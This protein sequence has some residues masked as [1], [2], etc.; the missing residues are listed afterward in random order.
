[1]HYWRSPTCFRIFYMPSV[2]SS[3]MFYASIC[4]CHVYPLGFCFYLSQWPSVCIFAL[5]CS[6]S[7]QLSFG[8]G[9]QRS[10]ETGFPR[11]LRKTF[12]YSLKGRNM[13]ALFIK[14]SYFVCIS[15]SVF[16]RKRLGQPRPLK[17]LKMG[18]IFYSQRKA[19]FC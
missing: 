6:L 5:I 14:I 17:V 3:L 4:Y 16:T 10:L 9:W 8:F 7:D 13:Y 2:M 11:G 15:L 18:E 19:T 12:P 1:M